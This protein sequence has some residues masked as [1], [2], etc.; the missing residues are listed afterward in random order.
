MGINYQG[1]ARHYGF[2]SCKI[3]PHCPNE[4]GDVEQRHF[5]LKN[6]IEQALIIRGRREKA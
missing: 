1:L 2:E 6:A 3:Q 4:N 5:R